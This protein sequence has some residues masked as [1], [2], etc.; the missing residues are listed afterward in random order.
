MA[1]KIASLIDGDKFF[2]FKQVLNNINLD[3]YDG[4]ILGIIGPSGSG[5][6]TCIR[7]LLGMEELTK[8]EAYF[9]NK[10]MPNRKMMNK[11]GYMGQETALYE[12]LTAHE[13]MAFFGK[14]KKLK[15]DVLN[16]EIDKNLEL[17][18]LS[19]SRNKVVSQFSGGMKRR[20]SLAISLIGA[21]DLLV[22]DE[23]TVGIDPKLRKTIWDQL[24]VLRD[25]GK[26]IVVT[27][28]VMSEAERCDKVALIVNGEIY[29]YG[30]PKELMTQFEVNSI[31][32]VFLKLE[33][34][35]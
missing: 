16:H 29:A 26:G 4:E 13:N 30:T 6:T 2:F 34:T 19:S 18:D 21:P 32:D 28:H 23:P 14:L 33:V 9:M 20:L 15:G 3:I 5:K 27:T 22:L 10:K 25:E 7:T 1:E 31:E 24:R 8:G 12:T 35:T 11:I 17:V